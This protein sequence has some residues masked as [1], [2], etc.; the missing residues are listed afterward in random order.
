V[1]II[2]NHII[3]NDKQK[4]KKKNNH[5]LPLPK[6][7]KKLHEQGNNVNKYS[8]CVPTSRNDYEVLPHI[9]SS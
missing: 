8:N 9:S 2:I 4:K 5:L 6:P 3:V 1:A 7:G